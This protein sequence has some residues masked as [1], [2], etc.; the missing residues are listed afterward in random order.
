MY[1]ITEELSRV[2]GIKSFRGELY[3]TINGV[4]T[5]NGDSI[6][7]GVEGYSFWFIHDGIYFFTEEGERR[8]KK[9][10]VSQ[11]L[12]VPLFVGTEIGGNIL[13]K[14]GF[15][16]ENRKWKWQLGEFDL[17]SYSE[18]RE[19]PF[20][21]YTVELVV[22]DIGIG[23]FDKNKIS[24]LDI[25]GSKIKWELVLDQFG[26]VQ[27]QRIL[28]VYQN[29]LLVVLGEH[30]L[31]SINVETGEILHKWHELKGFEI[32]ATY[33][34]ELPSASNFV[35]DEAVGK[36]IGAFHTYYF[37]I[38]LVSR[39]IIYI[40]L[41]EELTSHSIRNLKSVSNNPFTS[42]HLYLTAD[43]TLEEF[44]N[45]DLNAV[46]ALNR[47]TKKIDWVHTFKESGIGTNIPQI[48]DTHLYML[49]LEG[50]LHIFKK[51]TTPL[52]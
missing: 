33:K 11:L 44:P 6:I 45:T 21:N 38:D 29:E 3:Y 7:E 52:V 41:E 19:L 42:T 49:D 18:V 31:L 1:A 36:L 46:L 34:D 25:K 2:S 15:R 24:A 37:E 4:L 32:N 47:E 23:Y 14:S 17:E 28:G 50:T 20:E 30:V 16:R 43:V 22:A 51:E 40:Q 13:C 10:E 35:L 5:V 12:S 26:E 8:F 48:T 39:E 9:D 27:L